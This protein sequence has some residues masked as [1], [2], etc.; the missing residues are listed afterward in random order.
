MTHH[1]AGLWALEA[2]TRLE[3]AMD[4]AMFVDTVWTP[5]TW[6]ALMKRS[7]DT[8]AAGEAKPVPEEEV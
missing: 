6:V 1:V 5:E 7:C 3:V 8:L 4:D 2:V